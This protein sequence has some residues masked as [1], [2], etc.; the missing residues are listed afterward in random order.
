MN[1]MKVLNKYWD[2]DLCLSKI[3]INEKMKTVGFDTKNNRLTI[4][5]YDRAIYFIDLPREQTRYIEEAEVRF[6]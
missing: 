3:K 5:T 6:Y 2:S 4:V 1:F